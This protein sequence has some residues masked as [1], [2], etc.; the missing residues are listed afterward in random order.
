MECKAGSHEHG[1]VRPR[2][3]L[4]LCVNESARDTYLFD[5]AVGF[6]FPFTR[7]RQQAH[8]HSL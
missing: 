3:G 7:S 8:L 5:M 4:H 6:S 2:H 1:N